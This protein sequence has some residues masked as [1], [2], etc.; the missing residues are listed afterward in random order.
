[1]GDKAEAVKWLNKAIE[2]A[3]AEYRGDLNERLATYGAQG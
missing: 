1:M 2:L 3:P